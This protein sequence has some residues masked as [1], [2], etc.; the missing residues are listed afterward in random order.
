MRKNNMEINGLNYCYLD[1]GSGPEA[2]VFVHA[3]GYS[4]ELWEEQIKYFSDNYRIIA[5]DVRG[6]GDT[7]VPEDND[8]ELVLTTRD[9]VAL[10]DHLE[11][12]GPVHL[13]GVSWGGMICF[14]FL[15]SFPEKV[16]SLIL[17]D[18]CAFFPEPMR[19]DKLHAR[20]NVMD[21]VSMMEFAHYHVERTLGYDAPYE[22]FDRLVNILSRNDYHYYRTATIFGFMADYSEILQEINVPTLI[23]LGDRDNDY[24]ASSEYMLERIRISEM[25]IIPGAGHLS[26]IERPEKFNHDLENFLRRHFPIAENKGKGKKKRGKRLEYTRC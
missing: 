2:I 10:L 3:I 12:E 22:L 24:L 15:K 25:C 14:E 13:C 21:N 16:K 19:S 6:H 17:V 4:G 26:N 18:T 1:V 9:I 8:P 11:I 5:P 20:L 23:V 7:T